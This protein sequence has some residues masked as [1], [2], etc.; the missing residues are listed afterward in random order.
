MMSLQSDASAAGIALSPT[1]NGVAGCRDGGRSPILVNGEVEVEKD[2]PGEVAEE[3]P[4]DN[5]RDF[6]APHATMMNIQGENG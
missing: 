4:P 1:A 6:I 2:Y 3:Y 5:R